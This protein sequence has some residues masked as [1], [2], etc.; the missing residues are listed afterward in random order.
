MQK[1][2]MQKNFAG[3]SLPGEDRGVH[4]AYQPLDIRLGIEEHAAIDLDVSQSPLTPP[5]L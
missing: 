5:A 3:G 4:L 1:V 2:E